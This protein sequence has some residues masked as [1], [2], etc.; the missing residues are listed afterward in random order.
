M[1]KVK[2]KY[3]P[4]TLTYEPIERGIRYKFRRFFTFSFSSAILGVFFFL[5]YSYVFDSPQEKRL[6]RENSRLQSQY[7]I[8]DKKLQQ[9]KIVL[10]D[11]Q[12]RDENIYRVIYQ[13]DSI[14]NSV[15]RAGFGGMNRYKHLENLDNANMVINTSEKLDVIMKQLYVQSKSFDEIIDL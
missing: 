8:M 2:Y 10:D 14:P 1:S 6:A 11:I 12:Q 4:E 15:R 3:N 9:I 5:G 13:A 7:E